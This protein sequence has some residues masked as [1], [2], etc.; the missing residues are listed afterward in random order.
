MSEQDTK[1]RWSRTTPKARFNGGPGL[2]FSGFRPAQKPTGPTAGLEDVVF[3]ANQSPAK[4]LIQYRDKMEKIATFAGKEFGGLGG[5][6]A[7][8]AIRKRMGPLG[9]EPEEPTDSGATPGS[10]A[11]IKWKVNWEAFNKKTKKWEEE[12]SPRLFNLIFAHCTQEF[13]AILQGLSLIHI[14]EPTRLV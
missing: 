1:P 9:T 10:V 7:A 4:M 8:T 5:P 14:S 3:H 2:K 13:R 12:T 6:Q 11:M